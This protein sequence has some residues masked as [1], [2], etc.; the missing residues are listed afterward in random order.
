MKCRKNDQLVGSAILLLTAFIWGMAFVAQSTGMDHIEPFTMNCAR[1][2]LGGL[3]LLPLVVAGRLRA[4]S[5]A[6]DRAKN[7]G[8][9]LA[10]SAQENADTV[11]NAEGRA[12]GDAGKEKLRVTVIGGVCCGA[13]L[14]VASALQQFGICY[15]TVGK[16]GFITTLYIV[17]VPLAG[18]FWKKKVAGRVW[19]SVA[20]AALGMYLLCMNESFTINPG[21][22]YVFC[23]A[24]AF[25]GHILVIDHFSPKVDGVM[26]SCIQFFTCA[27]ISGIAMLLFEEP[28]WAN[29]YAARLPILYAGIMSS[30][31]GYTLQIIGQKHTEPVVASLIMSLESVFA[32]LGG[33]LLLNQTLSGKELLGCAVVFVGILLVQLPERRKNE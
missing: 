10:N 28:A 13:F 3:A 14:A 5:G 8:Q 12:S 6:A 30:G 1:S 26:M 25:T 11:V 31:V 29:I 16:A 18:I 32:V 33:W 21:D 23:C 15:T 20:L 19:I 9:T 4:R 7:S 17:M 27:V 22:I 2:V 24:I